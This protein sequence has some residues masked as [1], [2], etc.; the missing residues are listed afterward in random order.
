MSTA[1]LGAKEIAS[2]LLYRLPNSKMQTPDMSRVARILQIIKDS[3]QPEVD[4]EVAS[5]DPEFTR[6]INEARKDNVGN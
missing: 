3:D 6:A 1:G 4:F 2:D 5:Q